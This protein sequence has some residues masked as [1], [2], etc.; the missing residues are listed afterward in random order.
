MELKIFPAKAFS[1]LAFGGNFRGWESPG[2][3][4]AGRTGKISQEYPRGIESLVKRLD[5]KKK[6][7]R[8]LI[9]TSLKEKIKQ[10]KIIPLKNP[11]KCLAEKKWPKG[12]VQMYESVFLSFYL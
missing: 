10:N 12:N 5:R 3:V 11:G 1:Y 7:K 9:Y 4:A 8:I 2:R 6:K